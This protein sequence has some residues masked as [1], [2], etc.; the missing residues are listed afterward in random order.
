MPNKVS[1]DWRKRVSLEYARLRAQKKFRHQDDIKMAWNSN[2]TGIQQGLAHEQ[3]QGNQGDRQGHAPVWV[4]SEDPPS[5]SQFIRR[6][7]ARDNEGKIQSIPIKIISSV[8][9]IPN[10]YTWA[11]IQ[12]NFMVED[13]TVLHNIPYMG[14]EVLDQDGMFIEELIK[15]YDGKVH[16]D[17]EGGFIDDDLFVDLVN[18]L[19]QYDM[20]TEQEKPV[21][22]VVEDEKKTESELIIEQRRKDVAFIPSDTVFQ[23]ISTFFPDMGNANKLCE[24]FIELTENKSAQLK[25]CTPNIDTRDA[26]STGHEQTMHSFNTLFCRRCFKYDCFLHRL[27]PLHPRPTSKRRGPE[28]RLGTEPCGPDCYL[29]L[30][31]VTQGTAHHSQGQEAACDRPDKV[32]KNVSVDSG[33]EA[34]SEDSNDS[35]TTRDST[36]RSSIPGKKSGSQSGNSSASDSRRNS[37]SGLEGLNHSLKEP[38]KKTQACVV[39]PGA[40]QGHNSAQCSG[41]NSNSVR[42]RP[43]DTEKGRKDLRGLGMA[44]AVDGQL[45]RDINPGPCIEEWSGAEESM[46]RVLYRVFPANHCAIAQMLVTKL[47]R[48]VYMHAK[49]EAEYLNTEAM[50]EYTPPKKKKKKQHRLWSVH[51]KKIQLKK[52]NGANPVHNYYPCDHP[53]QA[54]DHTCPCIRCPTSVRSSACVRAIVRTGSLGAAVKHSA[55]LSSAPVSLPCES[56]TLTSAPPAGLTS[57]M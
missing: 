1:P 13:E 41:S 40:L 3:G 6:A 31:E 56:A 12:Q 32:K 7:E 53:G 35:E 19:K 55:P 4:C 22:E 10:M 9:P 15:N 8:N 43:I 18:A 52:D 49:T 14:D 50:K 45:A 5:H 2:R 20:E 21:T 29:M 30:E 34:S 11:P 51:C 33:N 16:G 26:V 36:T 24:K 39:G 28:M 48:Q 57:M 25:E 17:R 38:S 42:G 37:F 47:C 44:A 27:Q 23:A 46:F 54:C